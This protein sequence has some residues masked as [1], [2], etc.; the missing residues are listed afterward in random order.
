MKTITVLTGLALLS[1]SLTSCL[2]EQ[3]NAAQPGTAGVSSVSPS[4]DTQIL[5][6]QIAYGKHL[7]EITGC[8][9]CHSPKIMT[10]QGPAPDPK[11]LLSGH[12]SDEKLAVVT[13]KSVLQGY[14]LF[15][16]NSTAATGPWGTSFSGNL[17]PDATGLGSWSYESFKKALREG[18]FKGLDGSRMLLPPMPWPNYST[19]TDKETAAI[20]AYLQSI[21]PVR[22]IVPAPMPPTG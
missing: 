3:S 19:L 10:P 21:P 2:W 22:N 4:T 20:W 7:V 13:D 1:L 15:N 9:D 17:T 11:R 14:V 5:E 16:M 12:P 6:Q 18:K 8:N